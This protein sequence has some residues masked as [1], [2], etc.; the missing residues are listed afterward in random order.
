LRTDDL[1]A[2]VVR[3]AGIA[4]VVA[5]ALA[6]G[7]CAHRPPRVAY[8]R[9]VGLETFDA[10]WR[11]VHETYFDTTFHG[12]NWVALR[13]SLRPRAA[14]ARS[15]DELRTLLDGMLERLGRSHFTIIPLEMADTG[16]GADAEQRGSVG[17]DVRLLDGQLV[18]T[19]VEAGG[20]AA[21]AGVRPG[22]VIVAVGH[23][24]ATTLLARLR[25]RE[26][27]K[28]SVYRIE[29][30]A[31][32]TARNRL[33][34][35]PDSA[36]DVAFLDHADRPVS[37]HLVA[38]RAP[39]EPVRLGNLPASFT[40]FSGERRTGPGGV[41]VGVLR[42]NVWMAPLMR[43]ID[44][45]VDSFRTLDGIVL[46]LRGNTGGVGAMIG[47]VAGHFLE[48]RDTLGLMITRRNRL[49]IVANPRLVS[50]DARPVRPFAGPV[51]VLVDEGS[52]SATEAFAGGMQSLGRVRVFGGRSM[53]AVL[54][55]TWDRLPNGDQLYHAIL[56][57]NIRGADLEGRGV[58]PDEPVAVTRAD[59]LA[60]RNPV[61]EAAVRWIA[62]QPRSTSP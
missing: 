4:A 2:T 43:R 13:D 60:G 16:G 21:R 51:A 36:L 52:A 50:P 5:G 61:M 40:R 49:A 19:E 31:W 48:R 62:A 34:P 58:V 28:A 38:E 23:D 6:L 35:P 22:W 11:I 53:G 44:A 12:V 59:L 42:F 45:T 41:R 24:S 54:G 46:D 30:E 37:L 29:T 10:A 17:L 26:R 8:D 25:A 3:T 9:A 27:A 39:G 47:G 56:A 15:R 14:D 55:A 57:F 32:G 7:A 33:N 18:V 1:S 20:P